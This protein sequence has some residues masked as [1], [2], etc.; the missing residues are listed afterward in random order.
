MTE[1][2]YLG[3]ADAAEMIRKRKLSPVEYTQ[4]LL[5]RTAKLDSR[6]H[7]FIRLTPDLAMTAARQAEREIAAG[8]S[9][10]L[11]H[12]VPFALKDIIDFAGLPTTA[13]SKVLIDNVA[14]ADAPV[15]ARLVAAGG[16]MMG[17]LATHEFAIGGPSFDLPWPPAVNPWGG[18]HF[19]GGSSSG[20]GVA[21]AAG[22]VPA[23][24]G[25]DT[26]GSVRNP[27]SMCGITGMKPTYGRVS[28]RG[29]LP[30]SYSLDHVGPMTRTVRDNAL[31]LQVLAGHDAQDPGSADEAVP[32]YSADLER[33]VKGLKIGLI[34]HFYVEDLQAHPE[35]TKAIEEAAEVLRGLGAEVREIRLAPLQDYATCTRIIIRCEAFA[36]HRRWMAERPGDYG[37]LARQRIL[38]GAAVS[39][40]DYIDALRLRG[41]LT[42]RT[43]EAFAGIDAALTVSN[44]DP[45]CRIDDAEAC[46]R[47]YPRQ[48][49]QPFNITGQPA[50]A[51]PAGFTQDGMPLSLQLIGHPF[52]EAMVYRIAGAYERATDWTRRHP[53]GL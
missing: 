24:L 22:M 35:Q 28:R 5:D 14:A 46:A 18:S 2:A 40:A 47:L 17:K 6:Y 30:L 52:Q 38:D 11:L 29:V 51:M 7:A 9:R 48:A 50:I 42:R 49:R 44:M 20:S 37:D 10:G 15:T 43:L 53:P 13:H 19:P 4:A 12:G 41:R 3:V 36:I 1:L 16:I 26:G 23:A 8:G 34:R 25:T 31:L 45:A 39:A 33:G 32:D 21:L 27:A